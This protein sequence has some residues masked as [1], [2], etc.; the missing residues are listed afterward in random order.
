MDNPLV[1]TYNDKT[2]YIY[3]ET[4]NPDIANPYVICSYTKD[5]RGKFKLDKVEL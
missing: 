3:H 4:F 2:I 5:G 1:D